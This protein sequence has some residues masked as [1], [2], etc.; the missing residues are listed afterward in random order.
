MNMQSQSDIVEIDGSYGEGGGQLLRT[1]V[2]LSAITQRP[3][4]IKAIRAGRPNPGLQAQHLKGVEAVA[5]LCD[6]KLHGARMGSTELTFVPGKISPRSLKVDIGTAGAISLVLQALTLAAAKVDG[7]TTIE[8]TG[9]TH[10]SWS[11]P[12]DYFK[13]VFCKHLKSIGIEVDIE[14]LRYGF[15]PKGGGRVRADIK[16][17]QQWNNMNLD[18]IFNV[19]HIVVHSVASEE[20]RNARVAE[21]QIEGFKSVIKRPITEKTS[22]VSSFSIGSAVFGIANCVTTCLGGDALGKKGIKAEQIGQDAAKNLEA[23]IR[24]GVS[25]D[26]HAA[27]M[28]IPYLALAEGDSKFTLREQSGHFTSVQWLVR[29]FVDTEFKVDPK[30]NI[31]LVSVHPKNTN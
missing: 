4:K 9:G 7:T 16:G 13:D 31:F 27:D 30:G 17:S 3:V 23:E 25:L 6:A 28:I 19:E 21:R 14:L 11:P 2:A 26:I 1:A 18:D 12:V 20:L 29:H 22:Y 24:H 15:Y 5:S 10:V 8:L